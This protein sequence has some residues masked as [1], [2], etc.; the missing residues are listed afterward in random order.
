MILIIPDKP[1]IRRK[2]VAIGAVD[3]VAA[4]NSRPSV[5]NLLLKKDGA[6]REENGR[7]T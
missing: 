7:V 5:S 4:C 6:E 3:K 2:S 1:V